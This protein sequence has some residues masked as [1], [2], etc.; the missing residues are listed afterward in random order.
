MYDA[1]GINTHASYDAQAVDQGKSYSEATE[2]Y[3]S[4]G[5]S[6]AP[7]Y[8]AETACLTGIISHYD[9]SSG[10]GSDS[11]IK[12]DLNSA[13]PFGS[14]C[15]ATFRTKFVGPLLIRDFLKSLY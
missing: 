11:C 12:N 6:G 15:S 7:V 10:D 5:V 13:R 4:H 3:F 8:Q 2:A 1:T 14:G 9:I